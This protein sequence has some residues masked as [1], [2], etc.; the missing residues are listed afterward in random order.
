MYVTINLARALCR[1]R[2]GI[3]PPAGDNVLGTTD[4]QG[5]VT[6][7]D[8][9][10]KSSSSPASVL[11]VDPIS[12]S[13]PYRPCLLWVDVICVNQSDL[14]ERNAQVQLMREIY[15]NATRVIIWLG[16][17]RSN[18][19]R[20]VWIQ[21]AVE[22]VTWT[23]FGDELPLNSDAK[24]VDEDKLASPSV[25]DLIAHLQAEWSDLR[26][27]IS[28]GFSSSWFSRAWC[29]QEAIVAQRK[30]LLYHNAKMSSLSASMLSVWFTFHTIERRLL[31]SLI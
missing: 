17:T 8:R 6:T 5:I 25:A 21:R 16:D 15:S 31:L 11:K 10:H 27:T 13:K 29:E 23:L 18:M 4:A 22:L 30:F 3:S 14:D 19:R 2:L 12:Q 1:I 24:D 20:M 9:R 26:L 7:R 28:A